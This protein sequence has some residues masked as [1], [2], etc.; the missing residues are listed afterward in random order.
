ML[1]F[2]RLLLHRHYMLAAIYFARQMAIIGSSF[3]LPLVHKT[4]NLIM[5]PTERL[6]LSRLS[7]LPPQDSVSTNSTTTAFSRASAQKV[8]IILAHLLTL[9]VSLQL[10]LQ[11]IQL[12]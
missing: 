3:Q 1:C 6:E 9:L 5:V 2:T 7:P 10:A 8:S 11:S 12:V 4:Y